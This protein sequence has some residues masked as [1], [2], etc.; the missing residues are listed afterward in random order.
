MSP[1][2]TDILLILGCL[3]LSAFFAASETALTALGT[4]KTRQIVE[5]SG[6]RHS[7]R[8]WLRAPERVLTS[9]IIGGTFA[10]VGAS[11]IA[12]DLVS[13]F[14]VHFAVA[15]STGAI[16]LALLT[17]GEITPKTAAKAHS[18]RIARLVMP[19]V[20][21]VQ[22]LL[23]PL[24]IVFVEIAHLSIRVFGAEA[25]PK[26]PAVTSEE[27]EYLIGLGSKEGVLDKVKQELLTSVLDFS[28]L[29]VKETMLPRTRMVA[30]EK[31]A[32]ANEL[33][34]VINE[35]THSRIPV[36]QGT[37]DNIVGILH[38]K[39]L[40]S[41]LMASEPWPADFRLD[42][43]VRPAFFVPEVMKIS[44]LLR[45]F[46]RRRTHLAIVVDE[47]GGTSGLVTME[48]VIEEIVGEIDDEYDVREKPVKTIS[49]GVFLADGAVPLRELE[50]HLG[51]EFPEGG[52]YETLGGFLTA[53]A[54]KVPPAGSVIVWRGITF[55]VRASD[56]KRVTKVEISKKPETPL[57]DSGGGEAKV[58]PM[59]RAS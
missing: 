1:E 28:N 51:I 49:A 17:F 6:G 23:Y 5:A 22:A 33:I 37:I 24:A 45:E 12:T 35:S 52:D 43:Y 46:Q 26:R 19:V 57:P 53:T 31:E 38:V 7:L 8:V 21:V 25:K 14:G 9:L 10:N 59:P 55:T 2:L 11:A 3:A 44:R 16:T 54:G 41:D 39:D 18:E 13:R 20:V 48:D 29:I 32:P 47:F 27:I 34:R 50:P 58:I 40:V 42:K 30:I 15:L 56:E 4:A 36:Y